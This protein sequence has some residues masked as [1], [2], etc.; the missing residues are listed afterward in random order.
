MLQSKQK[1][2]TLLELLVVIT[3]LAVLSVGALVAYE[4]LGENA[5]NVAAA[6]NIKAADSS[7]RAFRAIENVYPNQWDNL[8]NLDGA[9]LS[10]SQEG[11]LGM[12]AAPTRDFFG[13]WQVTATDPTWVAVA[14]AMD[15]VGINELQTL[16][17]TSTFLPGNIPNLAWNESNPAADVDPADE[18]EWD[19]TGAAQYDEATAATFNLSIVPS[20]GVASTCTAGSTLRTNLNGVDLAAGDNSRLNLINDNLDDDG[21]DLVLALG[22]GKDVPGTTLGSRVA[23]STAPTYTNGNVVNPSI[24][25]ARYVALFHAATDEDGDGAIA[26]GEVFAKPRLIAVVDTEGRVI[27]QAIANSFASN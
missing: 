20:S 5:S 26:A 4:G 9:A 12:L 10:T 11:A 1:G 2:F 13:Q 16:Q 27:D 22:F 18:L 15:S 3:L 24:H 6:N 21:C 14:A 23:I 25:Y 17:T 8:A 19:A 7:I